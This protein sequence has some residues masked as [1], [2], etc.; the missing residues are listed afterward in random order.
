MADQG[1]G[2]PPHGDEEMYDEDEEM[3]QQ[4]LLASLM[5][6]RSALGFCGILGA[7]IGVIC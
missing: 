5:E 7:A 2:D 1:G 6:A 3:L 4:A